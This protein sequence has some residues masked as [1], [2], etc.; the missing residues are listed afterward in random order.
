MDGIRF[1]RMALAANPG[2]PTDEKLAWNDWIILIIDGI[3]S[4]ASKPWI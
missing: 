1:I 3:S 2:I 4:L